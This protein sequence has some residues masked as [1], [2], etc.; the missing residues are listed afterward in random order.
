MGYRGEGGLYPMRWHEMVLAQFTE[1][2]EDG[3]LM[4]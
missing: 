4:D 3:E 1:E 2:R